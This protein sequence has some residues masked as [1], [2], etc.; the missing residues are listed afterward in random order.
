MDKITL[1]MMTVITI[2]LSM[3]LISLSFQLA[4]VIWKASLAML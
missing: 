3:I 1:A 2:S 4:V